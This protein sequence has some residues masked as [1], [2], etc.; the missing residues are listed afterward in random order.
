LLE[1]EEGESPASLHRE[2]LAVEDIPP[3]NGREGGHDFGELRGELAPIPRE[4]PHVLGR[5]VE[6]APDA[7]VLVLDPERR[8]QAPDRVRRV[9]GRLGEHGVDG[10]EVREPGGLEASPA[11]FERDRAEVGSVPVRGAHRRDRLAGRVGDGVLQR[12]LLDADPCLAEH[13]FDERADRAPVHPAKGFPEQRGLGPGASCGVERLEARRHVR[14][15][16]GDR[17]SR[18]GAGPELGGDVARVGVAAPGGRDRL[19]GQLR[20]GRSER[21][22]EGRAPHREGA[23]VSAGEGSPAEVGHRERQGRVRKRLEIADQ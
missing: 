17:I 6:L 19:V 22:V 4:E 7:V 21:G 13:R 10:R 20:P 15:R 11:S 14:Q 12:L 18:H 1:A 5:L 3:G 16:D 8:A 2:N 23:A 9:R